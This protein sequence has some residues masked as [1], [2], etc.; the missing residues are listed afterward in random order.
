M[1]LKDQIAE[2]VVKELKEIWGGNLLSW[3]DYKQ[4][5]KKGRVRAN[6]TVA[7]KAIHM[8][9][10]PIAYLIIFGVIT[11]W[12]GFLLFPIT[13]ISWFFRDFSAWWILGSFF[14]ALFLVKISRAGH[15]EGMIHGAERNDKLYELLV[16]KGAFL[17]SPEQQG[18][19]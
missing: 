14:A 7:A 15:C 6:K 8:K 5:S 10:I 17:F 2:S 12:L 16:R 1:D 18:K 9:G 11:L 19:H 13:L 3:E 4:A